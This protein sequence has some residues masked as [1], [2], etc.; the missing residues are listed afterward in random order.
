MANALTLSRFPILLIYL[1]MLYFGNHIVQL[2]SVPLLFLALMIDSV[3]GIVARRTGQASLTGSVLDIVADRVYEL[4][5]WVSFADLNVIP[6]LIPII[7]ITRT[8]WT[9]AIRSIGVQK[10]E[11][12]FDQ[13]KS[14]LGK[15][16]V[17]SP[18]MRSIY[19]IS[20]I[21]SFCGLALGIALGAFPEGSSAFDSSTSI[22]QIFTTTSWIAVTLCV[23]RGA[24]V[25]AG[26]LRRIQ[27][28]T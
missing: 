4:V 12:P 16:I 13:I 15:F 11:A 23:I 17:G 9:D 22:L 14:N 7:V 3:D 18:W 5:L 25:I 21:V 1:L 2:L 26:I 10:G 8:T 19:G 20:K 28:S 6:V 24:P 27:I